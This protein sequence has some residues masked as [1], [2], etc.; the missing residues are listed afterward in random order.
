M[1]WRGSPSRAKGLF[2]Q[3]VVLLINCYFAFVVRVQQA[4]LEVP[5]VPKVAAEMKGSDFE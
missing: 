3:N 5:W 1:G 2:V 4:S